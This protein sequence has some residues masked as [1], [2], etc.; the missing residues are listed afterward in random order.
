MIAYLKG[1]IQYSTDKVVIVVCDGVGYKVEVGGNEL[2]YVVG[3]ECEFYI[4]TH[5][6]EN[7]LRLFGFKTIQELQIFEYLLDVNGVGP[8]VAMSLICRLGANKVVE[9]I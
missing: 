3:A 2:P 1:K 5:V 8:K 4:H 6:R 7:E 9:S